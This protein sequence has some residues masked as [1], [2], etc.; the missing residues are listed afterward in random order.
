MRVTTTRCDREE[1][2]SN[3]GT[4]KEFGDRDACVNEIG[5]DNVSTFSSEECPSGVDADRLDACISEL[6]ASPCVTGGKADERAPASCSR[7]QLCTR[8]F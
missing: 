2:C 1:A 3:V 8:S 4:G 5:H 6:K 7:E